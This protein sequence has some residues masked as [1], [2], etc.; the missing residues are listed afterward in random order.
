MYYTYFFISNPTF[1]VLGKLLKKDRKALG[2]LLK[3][4]S[5]FDKREW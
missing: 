4:Y 3:G 2:K 5:Y 1:G